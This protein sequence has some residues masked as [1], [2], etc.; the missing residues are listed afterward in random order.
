MNLKN[1]HKNPECVKGLQILFKRLG[2]NSRVVMLKPG[3]ET[4]DE[5]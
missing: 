4:N 1:E 2:F 3:F 5:K